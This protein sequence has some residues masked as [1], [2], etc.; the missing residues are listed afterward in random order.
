MIDVLQ[1]LEVV[2]LSLRVSVLLLLAAS[3]LWR[4]LMRSLTVR[5]SK[6]LQMKCRTSQSPIFSQ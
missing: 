4:C 3:L 6:F 1:T 2:G 5:A